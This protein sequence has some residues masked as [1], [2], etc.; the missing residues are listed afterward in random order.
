MKKTDQSLYR[1]ALSFDS[2]SKRRFDDNGFMHVES[3]HITKEQVV[4]YWGHE[5]PNW[6][7]L[8]LDPDKKYFGYRPADELQKAVTTFNGLPL[9]LHHHVE[10]A[11]A[12]QKN[13]RI[14]SMGTSAVWNPPYIDNALSITDRTGIQAVEDGICREISSAYQYDP[15]FTPGE[16]DG[17]PYDFVMRNIRGNHVALVEEGRAGPDVVVAD[18]QIQQNPKKE[19]SVMPN[20]LKNFFKGAFDNNLDTPA[21]DE[22]KAALIRKVIVELLPDVPEEKLEALIGTLKDI[23]YAKDEDNVDPTDPA[24]DDLNAA[25]AFKLGEKD[26]IRK[27]EREEIPG[28][29][30]DNTAEIIAAGEKHERDKL[31]SEHMDAEKAWDAC[32]FD[33]D[34]P[35]IKAAFTKGFA[36]GMKDGEKDGRREAEREMA[37]DAKIKSHLAAYQKNMDAKYDAAYEV[38]RHVGEV[39]AT[40][41]DSANDIYAHALKELG[42]PAGMYSKSSARDVFRMAV[43]MQSKSIAQDNSPAPKFNGKFAGLND[44]R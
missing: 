42:V 26:E 2:H 28:G 9:L 22:D 29:Q 5:I 36:W 30:D 31:M 27:E 40:A 21:A 19:K 3:S 12:P 10:S 1:E 16:F 8:G 24:K 44:I 34:D 4:P 23:A 37:A 33:S 13:Y 35:A 20:K 39:R 18:A 38:S 43:K 32:G 41:F 6:R 7:S 15:D 11:S 25:E 17:T 14:G